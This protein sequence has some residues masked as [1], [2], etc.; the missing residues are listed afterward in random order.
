MAA[1][2]PFDPRLWPCGRTDRLDDAPVVEPVAQWDQ[3]HRES[4]SQFRQK[5]TA[6]RGVEFGVEF[7]Y[8]RA[9]ITSA[10]ST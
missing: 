7:E 4:V 3:R 5:A 6:A 2:M 8:P 10:R 9:S 1:L